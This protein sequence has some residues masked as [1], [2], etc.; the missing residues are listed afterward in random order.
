MQGRRNYLKN[1]SVCTKLI[2]ANVSSAF[3]ECSCSKEY[4]TSC[5]LIQASSSLTGDLC[6]I[7][8]VSSTTI[9]FSF[10][11]FHFNLD[12]KVSKRVIFFFHAIAFERF[13]WQADDLSCLLPSG[14]CWDR[15]LI[16][17]RCKMWYNVCFVEITALL[18]YQD[19]AFRLCW[20]LSPLMKNYKN[21]FYIP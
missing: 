3:I 14:C 20:S 15:L 12:S 18:I 10:C 16:V 9:D 2:Y 1:K 19:V 6:L 4:G 13:L 11:E 17:N 21:Y 7:T 8:A 5:G